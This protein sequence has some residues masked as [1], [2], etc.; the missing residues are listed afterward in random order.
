MI[1]VSS[2]SARV[3]LCI[4]MGWSSPRLAA[5]GGQPLNGRHLEG[6]GLVCFDFDLRGD[7]VA[8]ANPAL[9]RRF[10]LP[11]GFVVHENDL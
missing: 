1:V 7:P 10:C 11:T 3:S 2:S 4:S 5:E 6:W 8:H 9:F